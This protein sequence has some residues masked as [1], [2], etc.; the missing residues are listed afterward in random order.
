MEPGQCALNNPTGFPQTAAMFPAS[1]W[2]NGSDPAFPQFFPMGIGVLCGIRLDCLRPFLGMTNQPVDR[3]DHH[4]PTESILLHHEL[5]LR[6]TALP[7]EFPWRPPS[8]GA[9]IPVC[10]DQSDLALFPGLQP[11]P[12][13]WPAT[14]RLRF[15][16]RNRMLY[17][18]PKCVGNQFLGHGP[19]SETA[20]AD[21][22]FEGYSYQSTLRGMHY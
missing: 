10:P 16:R 8:H 13:P 7:A 20:A 19:S 11:L 15:F 5:L 12:A 2:D 9:W 4:Q 21:A 14:F 1:I 18:F 22:F 17:P 6:S 3:W